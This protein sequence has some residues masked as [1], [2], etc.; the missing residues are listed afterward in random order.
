MICQ[1][2]NQRLSIVASL[3]VA[4]SL[5]T[6]CSSGAGNAPSSPV[7]AGP[8]V[9]TVST[10]DVNSGTAPC[11]LHTS[12]G[13]ADGDTRCI[14][15]PD[16][17]HGVQFHYGPTNYD[18]PVEVAK[19]TLAPGGE[20]TDC[21]FFKTTN[22]DT[23]YFNAYHSRM[24]A[25]SHHMLL[26]VQGQSGPS[27]GSNGGL[28][29]SSGPVT[30][31][32][33]NGPTDCNQPLSTSNLFG[34]QTPT[35]DVTSIADAP[36]DDGLAVPI[37]PLQQGAL[38]AHFI[39]AT[40][41]PILREVWAN[42]L[43]VDKSEVTQVGNPI[44]FLGGLGMN[45]PLGQS[46][47]ITGT[48][49]VPS[50][51]A[52]D[53]RLIIGTGHY[54]AHTTKFTAW[55]TINGQKQ[56]IIQETGTLGVAPEPKNWYFDSATKN[57]PGVASGILHMQTGDTISWECDVTNNNVPGGIKFANAVYT[58]EMCN[59]FGLYAPSFGMPWSATNF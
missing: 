46:R 34:A 25:G 59:M 16:P 8:P 40:S 15:P 21:I 18:D 36:E 12:F 42:V 41:K 53:F 45:V 57:P 47:A 3:T 51:V 17:A 10:V 26:Y 2:I 13:A 44:F 30:E 11:D 19:Y 1:M 22:Q 38:Q 31:T 56:Q 52:P 23:V 6:S 5:S 9:Q 4:A 49:T 39:N 28:S 55:A 35:L 7:D 33:S 32:G 24:R 37:P 48:A 27:L 58:G 14:L 43:Y 20:V 29:L 54:H 50:D